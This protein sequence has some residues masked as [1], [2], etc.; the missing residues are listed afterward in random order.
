MMHI[1]CIMYNKRYSLKCMSYNIKKVYHTIYSNATCHLIYNK[2]NI[3]VYCICIYY[4]YMFYNQSMCMA[5]H[6]ITL[7]YIALHCITLHY[8]ALHCIALHYIILYYIILY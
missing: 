2:F 1:T 5:L 3:T 7:Y 6:C 8:I 4:I